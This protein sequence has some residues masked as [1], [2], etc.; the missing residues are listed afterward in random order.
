MKL[1]NGQKW[2]G[3][4][5]VRKNYVSFVLHFL[6]RWEWY[7]CYCS[8]KRSSPGSGDG[9]FLLMGC[10]F[11]GDTSQKLL[12]ST[13]CGT[14]YALEDSS[15]WCSMFIQLYFNIHKF[16]IKIFITFIEKLTFWA[17]V[18]RET[19]QEPDTQW[20]SKSRNKIL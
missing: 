14:L 17:C 12:Q 16:V 19:I 15:T 18:L 9:H 10:H 2:K 20:S 1:R 4:S 3:L 11:S 13:F 5:P 6:C 8:G 7:Y